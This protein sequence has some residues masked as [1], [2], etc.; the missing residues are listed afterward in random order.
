VGAGE[1]V[2]VVGE[3]EA[4]ERVREADLR[5]GEGARRERRRRQNLGE[6]EGGGAEW[7]GG[8]LC[9]ARVSVGVVPA[10]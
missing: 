9:S 2:V 7:V 6:G 5:R 1:V 10:G 3:G 4:A 8:A